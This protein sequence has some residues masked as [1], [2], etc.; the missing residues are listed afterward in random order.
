VK[1]HAAVLV[2]EDRVFV[3]M[4]ARSFG[5][6]QRFRVE[7]GLADWFLLHGELLRWQGWWHLRG[8]RSGQKYRFAHLQEERRPRTRVY[9]W[10]RRFDRIEARGAA[11]CMVAEL[12]LSDRRV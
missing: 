9:S 1:R 11:G 8:Q 6:E 12:T 3:V 5:S 7:F 4:A 2:V 10:A